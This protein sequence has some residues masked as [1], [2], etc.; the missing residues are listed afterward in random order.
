MGGANGAGDGNSVFHTLVSGETMLG[1][2]VSADDN[3]STRIRSSESKNDV[4][5]GD[6]KTQSTRQGLGHWATLSAASTGSMGIPTIRISMESSRE[7]RAQSEFAKAAG[8][9]TF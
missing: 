1:R 7:A 9:D 2:H 3:A 6:V 8:D 5:N 4:T